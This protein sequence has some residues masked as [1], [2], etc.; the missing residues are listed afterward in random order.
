MIHEDFWYTD[1]LFNLR[2]STYTLSIEQVG[3]IQMIKGKSSGWPK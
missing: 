2:I 3:I 1:E